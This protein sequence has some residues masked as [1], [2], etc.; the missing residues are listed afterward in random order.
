LNDCGGYEG[1]GGRAPARAAWLEIIPGN[2]SRAD[3]ACYNDVAMRS[4]SWR[5]V[6]GRLRGFWVSK[7]NAATTYR[8]PPPHH[9]LSHLVFRVDF[10]SPN[11]QFRTIRPHLVMAM[12]QT[13]HFV[14]GVHVTGREGGS[15]H[16][17]ALGM[18][19]PPKYCWGIAP[20]FGWPMEVGPAAPLALWNIWH[21]GGGQAGHP[22]PRLG[23]RRWL[24]L[25]LVEPGHKCHT[26]TQ[27]NEINTP[28]FRGRI[29]RSKN[30]SFRGFKIIVYLLNQKKIFIN[31]MLFDGY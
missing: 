28:I 29:L 26:G 4:V 8:C 7:E 18:A 12:G 25:L 21:M 30:V 3:V 14:G 1:V 11:V 23:P 19:W 5:G 10:G 9:R 20:R 2:S 13:G 6:T 31:R 17:P 16:Q 15:H 27:Q 22:T 24:P